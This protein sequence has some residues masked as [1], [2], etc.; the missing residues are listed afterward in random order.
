MLS[1]QSTEKP[2]ATYRL[3]M[4]DC[5]RAYARPSFPE[6]DCIIVSAGTEDDRHG[7]II[8]SR[9]SCRIAIASICAVSAARSFCI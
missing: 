8:R 4:L 3:G 9:M 6:P 7:W 1:K 5:P 2:V